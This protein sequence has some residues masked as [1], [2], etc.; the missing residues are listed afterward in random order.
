VSDSSV[1][2]R[3]PFLGLETPRPTSTGGRLLLGAGVIGFYAEPVPERVIAREGGWD[4]DALDRFSPEH[5]TADLRND[6]GGL[7]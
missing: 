5:L 3:W 4:H 7:K 6:L 1:A 2:G